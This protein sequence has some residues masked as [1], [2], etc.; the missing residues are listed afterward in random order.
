MSQEGSFAEF[1]R[2][3]FPS[4]TADFI[5]NTVFFFINRIQQNQKIAIINILTDQ[6]LFSVPYQLKVILFGVL[7]NLEVVDMSQQGGFAEF[8]RQIFPSNI[9]EFLIHTVIFFINRI[10]Q[11]QKIAI[12]NILTDQPLFS[13]PYHQKS[14]GLVCLVYLLT[15]R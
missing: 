8:F 5:I 2:R 10:Q 12:I 7:T 3:I 13:V 4:N 14:K 15:W 11:N 1:I 6:P 9:A